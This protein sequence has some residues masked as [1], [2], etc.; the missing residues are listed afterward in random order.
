MKNSTA[1][2]FLPDYLKSFFRL[3]GP[4]YAARM[5]ATVII[6][7]LCGY[8]FSLLS[9]AAGEAFLYNQMI[10]SGWMIAGFAGVVTLLVLGCGALFAS[11][12]ISY[13]YKFARNEIAATNGEVRQLSGGGQYYVGPDI[14]VVQSLDET[15]RV[16]RARVDDLIEAQRPGQ[17]IVELPFRSGY[18][19]IKD[20][21]AKGRSVKRGGEGGVLPL[22]G[23]TPD[24]PV[25]NFAT[26]TESEYTAYVNS[27]L[28]TFQAYAEHY[29]VEVKKEP[30]F[31][32]GTITTIFLF[33][34]LSV[35]ATAQTNTDKVKTAVSANDITPTA[36]QQVHYVFSDGSSATRTA[37]GQKKISE[38]FSAGYIGADNIQRG[39]VVGIDIDRRPVDIKM[40]IAAT[41]TN[42]KP[43]PLFKTRMEA[44]HN[45]VVPQK[46]FSESLPD[47]ATVANTLNEAKQQLPVYKQVIYKMFKPV[48]EFAA[49]L[50]FFL[51]PL[52]GIALGFCNL[53]SR[54]ARQNGNLGPAV[55]DQQ[56]RFAA[57]AWWISIC[58]VGSA[59]ICITASMFFWE[60][61][62]YVITALCILGYI[63]AKWAINR[64]TP[65]GEYQETITT[66]RQ[67][68]RIGGGNGQ[69]F[70]NQ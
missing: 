42:E 55:A 61:N 45:E 64:L 63:P 53:V 48:W 29:R 10:L 8:L 62:P 35:C 24:V 31:K 34:L 70:L 20:D 15:D 37:D 22:W 52:F 41:G 59:Y 19:K 30:P 68:G 9:P 46:S 36:G 12:C 66:T 4:V 16:F 7:F 28:P 54:S 26:E 23:V 39:E 49:W 14:V 2:S 32:V 65:N 56:I 3:I 18:V 5:V 51:C 47:S 17:W 44:P 50:F 69:R 40:K 67:S 27:F 43:A 57:A 21:S 1:F 33:L 38:L 13:G 60:W 58:V 6:V 11:L 25:F